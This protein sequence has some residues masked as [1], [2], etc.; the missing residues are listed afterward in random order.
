MAEDMHCPRPQS[1]LTCKDAECH[2][3]AIEK[4]VAAVSIGATVLPHDVSGIVKYVIGTS[5]A[6]SLHKTSCVL[7]LPC[8]VVP[9]P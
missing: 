9:G 7:Y 5:V 1:E 8:P 4:L 3:L 2:C 6:S